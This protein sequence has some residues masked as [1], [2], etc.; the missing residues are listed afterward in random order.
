MP[1]HS[2]EV[3]SVLEKH[4]N[5]ERRMLPRHPRDRIRVTISVASDQSPQVAG[6]RDLSVTGIGLVW[7]R[8]VDPG[9]TIE[10]KLPSTQWAAANVLPAL[11]CH[12][13]ERFDGTWVLGCSFRRR[14]TAD[15]FLALAVNGSPWEPLECQLQSELQ[16]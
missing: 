13:T 12:A 2:L 6:I 16:R 7:D 4:S 11:I 14:A 3:T 5:V 9:T 8:Q 1:V 10:L 15:D